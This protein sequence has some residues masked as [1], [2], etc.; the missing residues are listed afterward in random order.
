MSCAN[1]SPEERSTPRKQLLWIIGILFYVQAYCFLYYKY[2]PH[3]FAFQCALLPIVLMTAVCTIVSLRTGTF[4]LLFLIPVSGS[5][6]YFF[7]LGGFNPLVYVFYA[8]VLGFLIHRATRP[9]RLE[10]ANPLFLPILGASSVIF[11]SALITLWR[12]TNFFPL[13]MTSIQ[14]LAVNVLDVSS[15]EAIRRVV[16]DSLNYLAGF[17][18]FI[19]II[20]ILK[21][22]DT[23]QKAVFYL[24]SA[25]ILSFVFGFYQ[26]FRDIKLG[27][28]GFFVDLNRVN[29]LFTDPNSLGVYI[30]LT[31]PVFFASVFSAKKSM[32]AVMLLA[33]LGGIG[34]TPYVGSRSGFLG[35]ISSSVFFIL[36]AL[37][38]V[39]GRRRDRRLLEKKRLIFIFSSVFI[40]IFVA[41]WVGV[42][43]KG[44]LYKRLTKNVDSVSR[45]SWKDDILRG[46]QLLWPSALHMIKD[47]PVSG[48]GVGS[49][50]CELPNVYKKYNIVPIAPFSFYAHTSSH[51]LLVDT[52]GNFYLHVASELG[53]IGLF[54]FLWIFIGILKQ[55]HRSHFGGSRESEL[56][57]LNAGVSSGLVAMFVIFLF[58]A[59]TLSFEIQLTFWLLVGILYSMSP[60][61]RPVEAIK[62]PLKIMIGLFIVIFA[63]IHIWN[64]FYTLS[65]PERTERFGL[66]QE[67]GLYQVEKM[68]GQEFRWTG[69]T[70]GVTV[71]VI[72]P[73]LTIPVI[74]SHPDIQGDPVQVKIFDLSPQTMRKTLLGGIV[75]R[76]RLWHEFRYDLSHEF[77][78]NIILFFEVSRT[79]RP[80][81]VLG[82]SDSRALGIGVGKLKLDDRSLS[83]S[84]R[85]DL[86]EEIV[87][88]YSQS[89]WEGPQDGHLYSKGRCWLET[90]LPEG[91][92]FFRISAKG[93]KGGSDWPYMVLWL[94]EE[95]V[96]GAWVSSDHWEFYRFEKRIKP[97][98]YKI[99]VEFINDFY[100]ETPEDDRNLYVGDLE[101][102]QKRGD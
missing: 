43:K 97:G 98:L 18:W 59:H 101:I 4:L 27:N 95:M 8:Y 49:F 70:A 7:R 92:T 40:L 1:P 2:V 72:R 66:L 58:G 71:N 75:L 21:A 31:V 25:T 91:D 77:G 50:T 85:E 33:A 81:D 9:A 37:I 88:Q 32:K 29:A 82:T 56:F 73:F 12:Y 96:G 54:F 99:S 80:S 20:N 30:A 23:I 22:R 61:R 102:F 19:V 24:A 62:T 39:T 14:E 93:Q 51:D 86:T 44:P 15:G 41:Y 87:R 89:D 78:S 64:S 76:D 16:F 74:A 10:R 68:D 48:V 79:W 90:S 53:L 100:G 26:A 46:R 52:S 65:I 28:T 13:F 34:L 83:G 36:F 5:L 42:S 17:I 35:L 94:N 38:A 67:F 11:L 55:I 45:S 60:T 84:E 47:F 3:I 69:K 57:H 63:S 6:P